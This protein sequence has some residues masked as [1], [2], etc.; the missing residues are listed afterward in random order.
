[1]RALRLLLAA[2]LASAWPARAT[3][4]VAQTARAVSGVPAVTAPVPVLSV[5]AGAPSLLAPSLLA[6]SLPVLPLAAAPLATPSPIAASPVRAAG[7]AAAPV[8]AP[9]ARERLSSAAEAVAQDRASIAP[10]SSESASSDSERQFRLLL[11]ET[12]PQTRTAAYA[13]GPSP[14]RPASGLSAATQTK[15]PQDPEVAKRVRGMFAGTAAMKIGMETVTLS[16]PLLALATMGGAT[17]VAGLVIV[18]GLA[19]A[20]F[21]GAAASLLDRLP[22]QKVLAAAVAAQAGLVA[23]IVT[24]GAVGLLTPLTLFPLYTLVGGAMGIAE[25]SRHS[26]PPLILGHDAEA[27]ERYNARLHI[28]YEVA[29][30]TG[31]L[32]TGALI[33]FVGPLWALALQP[34][35][36]LLGGV[37]F[38]RVKLAREA[39]VKAR[40]AKP[41]LSDLRGRIADYFRDLKAGARLVLGNDR[42][43]W[44]AVAFVL[45]QIVH[46]ILEGLLAPIFAKR[47]LANPGAAGYLMTASNMGELLGAVLLLRY[48]A[49]IKAPRWVKWTAMAMAASWLMAFTRILPL[50]LPVFLLMS[51]TWA[52]SDLS[53]RSEVQSTLD[54]KDQPRAASFLF[55]AFVLGAAAVSLGL[56][57]L[58]DLLPITYALA[59][60]FAFFT[61]V[62]AAV[63]HASRRLAP[64]KT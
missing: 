48:A 37:L 4:A 18:Y 35:A 20:A 61:A 3:A 10:V 50:V 59:G 58:F 38:L 23:S 26:I 39:A 5:S 49:K 57:A 56:G 30:V 42:L 60:V 36:Y 40:F 15:K 14:A 7:P 22:A 8:A 19:Q 62:A 13:D 41:A 47:V 54:E 55:S 27:L 17:L 51:M 9:T 12:A 31:A 34:P 29:G 46:R 43:R 63:F 11:G 1:M 52:A 64:P 21:A 2:V 44:V 53:L 6:P 32:A 16:I 25:T 45:P 33:T 24:L 28:F